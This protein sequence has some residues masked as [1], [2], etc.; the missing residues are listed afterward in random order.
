MVLI[1]IRE[2]YESNGEF[3]PGKKGISLTE[4]QWLTLQESTELINSAIE[5]KSKKLKV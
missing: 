4:A 1:D 5:D 2:Y 3:K